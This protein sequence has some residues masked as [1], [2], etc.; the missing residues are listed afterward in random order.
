MKTPRSKKID[1]GYIHLATWDRRKK[2]VPSWWDD[3]R[4]KIPQAS[5][6]ILPANTLFILKIDYPLTIPYYHEFFV[7]SDGMTRGEVIQK[8]VNCYKELYAEEELS[9]SISAS[10]QGT[11]INRS[12]TNGKYGIWGHV[13]SDLLLHTLIIR[14][15]R[16]EIS[17]DS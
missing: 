2:L 5:E 9:S 4:K 13:L 3:K 14:G 15:E 8:I 12:R 11:L 6:V 1:L 17:C 16:L 10:P 7:G